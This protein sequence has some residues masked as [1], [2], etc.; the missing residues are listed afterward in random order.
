MAHAPAALLTHMEGAAE[1]A[2]PWV[3]LES[4]DEEGRPVTPGE[5]G[6]F[7]V[8]TS[9]QAYYVV[10]HPDNALLFRDG[11]F[12]PRDVGTINAEGLITVTGRSAEVINRGS[13]I[14][15]PDLVE[16]VLMLH[17]SI[18]AAVAFGMPTKTGIEEIWAAVV[19]PDRFNEAELLH[20][21]R[22]R[23]A[24]KAPHTIRRIDAVPRTDSGKPKRRQAREQVLAAR[25]PA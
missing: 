1:Y 3:R 9:E 23:L 18:T 4:V 10:D 24:D 2:Y 11:W 20:F 13:S 22:E 8:K 12:Y 17:P 6:M 25:A 16:R 5:Q 7:R 19:A 21:C 14:V 15:A